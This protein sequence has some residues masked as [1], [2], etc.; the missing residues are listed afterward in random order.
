LVCRSSSVS[1]N[2]QRMG[3]QNT[4]PRSRR[5]QAQPAVRAQHPRA[6][7]QRLGLVRHSGKHGRHAHAF[8][9][10]RLERAQIFRATDLEAGRW[11]TLACQGDPFR[12]SFGHDPVRW[13]ALVFF[14]QRALQFAECF[15]SRR[16]PRE[17]LSTGG[18]RRV[19]R[20][21]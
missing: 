1:A 2:I 19:G 7:G 21:P 13:G 17:V 12:I 16:V 5:G 14:G 4:T 8:E 9:P 15:S 10:G 20:H 3:R 18:W 6:L 11:H